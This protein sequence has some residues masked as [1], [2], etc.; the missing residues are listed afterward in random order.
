MSCSG[1][2]YFVRRLIKECLFE[3]KPKKVYWFYGIYQ[4]EFDNMEGVAFHK[5][6]PETFDHCVDGNHNVIVL[7]DI[8]DCVTKSTEVEKL[9]SRSIME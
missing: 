2:S 5:G 4:S 6:L 1:K 8:Q 9:F 3:V 7:D